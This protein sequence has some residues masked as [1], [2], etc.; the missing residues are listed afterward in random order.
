M[1]TKKY[2]WDDFDRFTK[3]GSLV[4]YEIQQISNALAQYKSLYS[5]FQ[6]E[7]DLINIA[8]CFFIESFRALEYK[9]I[10]GTMRFYDNKNNSG[11]L[12]LKRILE[13]AK[14]KYPKNQKLQS[15]VDEKLCELQ[16]LNTGDIRK[17]RNKY[18]AHL[19]E[20]AFSENKCLPD[21][22][23][24]EIEALLDK[25]EQILYE[26]FDIVDVAFPP[27]MPFVDDLGKL[28][29]KIQS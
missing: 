14:R 10:V 25:A 5:H 12:S 7:L 9:V 17:L 18:Y 21:F 1:G 16:S 23:T 22:D 24:K 29:S 20:L 28:F 2:A 3:N 6:T 27:K 19:D 13:K 4:V 8:P 15:Y 26:L 11:S